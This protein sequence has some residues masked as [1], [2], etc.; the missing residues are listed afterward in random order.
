MPRV[1]SS[2][3][4]TVGSVSSHRPRITFCWLPPDS[5]RI[6]VSCDGVLTR[7]ERMHQSVASFI[8]RLLRNG[9]T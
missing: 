9:P 2:S 7:M 4:S 1:G 5:D 3:S 8:L 6:L